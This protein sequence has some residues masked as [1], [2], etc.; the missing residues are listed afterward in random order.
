MIKHLR[1]AA[2]L[3]CLAFSTGI[4][5]ANVPTVVLVTR[6]MTHLNLMQ[7]NGT[8]AL[9]RFTVNP[10]LPPPSTYWD[11][12]ANTLATAVAGAV[13]SE[14][15]TRDAQ[16]QA[17]KLITPL[18]ESLDDGAL[19]PMIR[20]AFSSALAERGMDQRALAFFDENSPSP[21]L[22]SRLRQARE[23]ERFLLVG[24][25]LPAQDY[26]RLPLTLG[27]RLDH[28]RLSLT[29]ELREGRHDRNRR[30]TR[31]DVLVY[32]RRMPE[33]GD[34]QARLMADGHAVLR[35]ELE[36]GVRLALAAALDPV[37]LPKARRSDHVGVISNGVMAEFPAVLVSHRDGRALLWS[38]Q[39]VL[40]SV[41]ADQVVTGEALEAE[42]DARMKATPE[43][44]AGP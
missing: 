11:V 21:A 42:L 13:I 33:A 30:V 5:Q 15:M 14:I 8:A 18:L 19:E 31:R 23:G 32:T 40:V 6:D 10:G 38:S 36:L 16:A 3:A 41:P 20:R 12:A 9:A 35:E 26:V 1:L 28:L 43:P 17:N 37:E 34:A 27:H 22:L 29:I 44:V 4:A 25:G 39:D 2:A 24:N 7:P